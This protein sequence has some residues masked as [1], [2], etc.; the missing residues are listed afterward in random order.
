MKILGFTV[1]TRREAVSCTCA[2]C[3]ELLP[4][5]HMRVRSTVWALVRGRYVDKAKETRCYHDQCAPERY[6]PD[7]H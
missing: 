7:A 5:G 4:P 1:K 6:R 3:G 2:T